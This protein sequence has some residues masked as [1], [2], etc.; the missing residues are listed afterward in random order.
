MLRRIPFFS[1]F[2]GLFRFNIT[3][4]LIL[5]LAVI[6]AA[7][8]YLCPGC[9]TVNQLL[10]VAKQATF[11]GLAAMG[12]TVVMLTG[13]IDL[14]IGQVLLMTQVLAAD[15]MAGSNA[16]ILWV[17]PLLLGLAGLIG[18]IN[19]AIIA[20]TDVPPLIMTF[21]MSSVIQGGYL[22][23]TGG[24]P[25]GDAPSII[26]YLGSAELGGVVPVPLLVWIVLAVVGVIV[27]RR[28]TFGESI[29]LV[30]SNPVTARLS[31]IDVKK[32]TILAYVISS[33]AAALAG[34][35][36]VGYVGFGTLELGQDFLLN[37]LAAAVIGGT[38]FA[39]GEGGL[40]GTIGGALV[41]QFLSNLL[42]IMRVGE[43]GQRVI[44]G[45]IIGGMVAFYEW[46]KRR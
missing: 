44:Q 1:G 9:L 22:L 39:G 12:Q 2:A 13:G 24:A 4:F 42:L 21:A 19:G 3:T 26:R 35:L 5:A 29:Y 32:I 16:N 41:M 38:T 31:G 37:P 18:L 40:L 27:L 25:T 30:G 33:C 34:I 7:T 15:L 45:L 20:Y 28:T 36:L 43:P 11:L 14:S 23:Y 8:A 17:L 10:R 6:I 46:R